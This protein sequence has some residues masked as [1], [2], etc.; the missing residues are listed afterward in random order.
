MPLPLSQIATYR[1]LP[2]LCAHVH[3]SVST[4]TTESNILPYTEYLTE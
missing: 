3:N 4:M 2:D 1:M